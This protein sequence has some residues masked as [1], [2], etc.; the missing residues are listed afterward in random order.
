MRLYREGSGNQT[1]Y[2]AVRMPARK[3]AHA[4]KEIAPA[5]IRADATVL[6]SGDNLQMIFLTGTWCWPPS[7]PHTDWHCLYVIVFKIIFYNLQ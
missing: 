7:Q 1:I 4:A 2:T 6:L 5:Q 3:P